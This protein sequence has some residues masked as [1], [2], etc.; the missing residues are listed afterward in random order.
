MTYH[1]ITHSLPCVVPLI[2]YTFPPNTA[3]HRPLLPQC[4][5]GCHKKCLETLAIKCGHKRLPRRLTTFGV[6]LAQHL[7][8][9]NTTVPHLVVKCVAEIDSR[10]TSIKVS[11]GGGEG[12]RRNGEGVSFSTCCVVTWCPLSCVKVRE[13]THTLLLPLLPEGNIYIYMGVR[14]KPGCL[15]SCTLP[16]LLPPRPCTWI[17]SVWSLAT[18][19]STFLLFQGYCFPISFPACLLLCAFRQYNVWPSSTF[20]HLFYYSLWVKPFSPFPSSSC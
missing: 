5:L 4:G 15:G 20:L 1:T 13:H 6:D 12:G 14:V 17:I 16:S 2:H 8:E 10:G 19:P 11:A 3:T 18:L 9:T 7:T